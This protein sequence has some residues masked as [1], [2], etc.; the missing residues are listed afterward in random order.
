MASEKKE[1]CPKTGKA[2][3]ERE[4]HMALAPAG[5]FETIG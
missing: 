1:R 5:Y 3:L 2:D 4:T